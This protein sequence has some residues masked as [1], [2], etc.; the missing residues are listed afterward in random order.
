MRISTRWLAF[1]SAPKIARTM[2]DSGLGDSTM[3]TTRQMICPKCG[4]ADAVR[5]VS[6]LVAD[7][8]WSSDSAGLG[9]SIGVNSCHVKIEL[10]QKCAGVKLPYA[11]HFVSRGV[12][13]CSGLCSIICFP[14]Q[15]ISS[16]SA[17]RLKFKK[18]SRFCCSDSKC[19]S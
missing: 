8:T 1:S 10:L 17:G 15:S 4:Q 2:E 12:F 11:E 19:A 16:R 9:L 6:A 5:K 18:I 3:H 7:G 14:R 13:L